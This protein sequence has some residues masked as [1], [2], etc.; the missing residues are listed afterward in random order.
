MISMLNVILERSDRLDSGMSGASL[1]YFVERY[2]TRPM[3]NVFP[4][5]EAEAAIIESIGEGILFLVNGMHVFYDSV[6]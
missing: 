1:G 3:T 5:A 6:L 2:P 4:T